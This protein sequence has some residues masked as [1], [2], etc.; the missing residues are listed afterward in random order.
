MKKIIFTIYICLHIFMLQDC[1]C[2]T[3]FPDYSNNVLSENEGVLLNELARLR[4]IKYDFRQKKVAFFTGNTGYVRVGKECYFQY[5][6]N[7]HST[8]PNSFP[9]AYIFLF[10]DNC[11]GYDAAIVFG[12]LKKKPSKDKIIRCLRR[13]SNKNHNKFNF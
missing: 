6:N 7:F 5:Y 9:L 3:S 1:F 8:Y 13:Q 10:E 2:Q 4:R 11:N 12:S